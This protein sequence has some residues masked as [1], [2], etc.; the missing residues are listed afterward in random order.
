[1]NAIALGPLLISTPRLYAFGCALLLLVSSRYLLGL[2][3]KQHGRWF[4]GL[5]VVWLL[6][7]AWRLWP[8]TGRVI[9]LPRSTP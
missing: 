4:N 8:L 1:M 5:L 7:H 2:P 3:A 9:A 6:G